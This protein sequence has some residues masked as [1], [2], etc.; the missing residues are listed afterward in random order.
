MPE[1]RG[2][3]D[4]LLPG[5]VT[6]SHAARRQVSI[7]WAGP[8]LPSSF[9]LSSLF[10]SET[11]SWLLQ[12]LFL[13]FLS[14]LLDLPF[15]ASFPPLNSGVSRGTLVFST[16]VMLSSRAQLATSGGIFGSYYL[17]G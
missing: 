12:T 6:P 15:S 10:F 9:L 5:L 7:V 14:C 11:L 16:G 13:L 3:G 2:G 8:V 1:V 4:A 17:G